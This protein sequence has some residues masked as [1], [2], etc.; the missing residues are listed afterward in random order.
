MS[1]MKPMKPCSSPGCNQLVTSG[2]C[3]K[4]SKQAVQRYETTRKGGYHDWYSSTR[5][6]AYRKRYLMEHPLCECKEC[7]ENGW[8]Y[9]ASVVDHRVPHK[10]DYDLFWDSDNHQA[11]YKPH[12][13]K[14]TASEDGGYKN[15]R[16]INL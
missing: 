14:K 9:A 3:E 5:W 12:H 15:K 10:G 6:K 11:M 7:T 8:V 1:P 2:K 13:D 16:E 4:H